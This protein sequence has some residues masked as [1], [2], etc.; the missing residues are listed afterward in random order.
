MINFLFGDFI[1]RLNNAKRLRS[2]SI[3]II[4]SK[5]NLK[6]LILFKKI[7]IIRGFHFLGNNELEVILKYVKN[8]VVFKKLE[9]VSVPSRRVYVDLVKLKKL[10]DRTNAYIFIVS[11]NRGLKTDF[12]CLLGKLSGELLLKIEL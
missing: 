2:K 12:E 6:T 10:K 9:L 11:T 3:N 8:E 7:G 5:L 4:N 1:T